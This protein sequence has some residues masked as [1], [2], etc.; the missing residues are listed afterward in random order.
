LKL[1]T[2][3]IFPQADKFIRIIDLLSKLCYSD[4]PLNKEL[5][6][7]EYA[8]DVR[9]SGYYIS[10]GQYLGLIERVTEG[11]EA[12]YI[13]TNKGKEIIAADPRSRNLKLV[14]II[15]SHQI[16]YEV[17]EMYIKSGERPL[18]EDIMAIMNNELNLSNTTI[19]RRSQTVEK[20][21]DWIIELT[22]M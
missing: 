12:F 10:A 14:E 4:S 1:K 7:T 11:R 3:K 19:F 6:T 13:P 8:F 20:W 9:Q 5:I 21:I 2:K 17:L 18:R 16:F 22:A 15:L